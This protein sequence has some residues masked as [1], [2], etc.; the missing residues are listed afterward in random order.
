MEETSTISGRDRAIV[1]AVAALVMGLAMLRP[2]PVL[3]HE[4]D[5]VNAVPVASGPTEAVAPPP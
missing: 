2:T 3:G 1:A 4:N 5:G